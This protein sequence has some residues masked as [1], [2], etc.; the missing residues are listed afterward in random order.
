MSSEKEKM[1]RGEYYR[2]RDSE[3]IQARLK[4]RILSKKFNESP[5]D[6]EALREST[7]R[8]LIPN[9]GKN[10]FIE[11]PF[12]CDYG[13]NITCGDNVYLNSNCTI[14][15]VCPVT[16]GSRV[17]LG[18]SVQ[19]YTATHPIVAIERSIGKEYG[20]AIEIGDDVWIGG[21]SII[22]PGVTI[23]ARSVIGA[24]S[25]VTKEIPADFVAAGNPCKIIREIV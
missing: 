13:E 17:K 16:I 5:P 3:L 9:S 2:P 4:A 7:L 15:D 20:K 21:G 22:C 25:V 8:E 23:G 1:L 10:L 24:G 12:F 14:L 19:I 18:P 6:N 11:P